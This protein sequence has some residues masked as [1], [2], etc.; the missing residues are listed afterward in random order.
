MVR[1]R[2]GELFLEMSNNLFY[3]DK[4]IIPFSSGKVMIAKVYS[5]PVKATHHATL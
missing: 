1:V 5:W 4:I 3:E 2:D